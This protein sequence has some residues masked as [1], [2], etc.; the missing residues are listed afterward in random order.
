MGGGNLADTGNPGLVE[1]LSPRGRGKRCANNEPSASRRSIPA[2]AGETLTP[3]VTPTAPRVYPRVGGGNG[4][5]VISVCA[6]AGLSPRGRGKPKTDRHTARDMRSIPAWAGETRDMPSRE[7]SSGV[8]P[9][10]GGG[11]YDVL[12]LTMSV[13]GLSPRGRG[14]P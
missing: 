13:M 5:F 14:K 9:R 8:Y 6:I 10:V 1:G 2:W 7:C 11:N 12:L 4:R 3:S